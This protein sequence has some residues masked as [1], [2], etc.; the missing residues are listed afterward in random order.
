MVARALAWHGDRAATPA[1]LEAIERE[2]AGDGL[3]HRAAMPFTQASPDHGAMPDLAYLLHTLAWVR[4]ERAIPVLERVV[5]RLDPTDERLRDQMSGLFHYVDSVCDVAERLGSPEC[6]P[7]LE[8]LGSYPLLRGHRTSDGVQADY[9]LERLAHLE[10]VINRA[11]A[12]CGSSSGAAVLVDYL[13]D[14][15]RPLARHAHRELVSISG[16][17]LPGDPDVWEAW[18][19]RLGSLESTPWIAERG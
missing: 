14:A 1:L 3:P 11:I 19:A 15:R 7:V 6:I 12:R 8:R 10:L 2:L 17:D 18:L 5:E 9:F 16:L 4:D 13:R